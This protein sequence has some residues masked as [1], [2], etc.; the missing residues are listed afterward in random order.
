MN[1]FDMAIKVS[2]VDCA[3]RTQQKM[4]KNKIS[5][6]EGHVTSDFLSFKTMRFF[7]KTNY[8]TVKKFMAYSH[9]KYLCVLLILK[10]VS[11]VVIC[12][13]CKSLKV[14][15]ENPFIQASRDVWPNTCHQIRFCSR[16]LRLTASE[17][18]SPNLRTLSAENPGCNDKAELDRRRL[19]E[20][21]AGRKA[22]LHWTVADPQKRAL[23]TIRKSIEFRMAEMEG[24]ICNRCWVPLSDC[25]CCPAD[26]PLFATMPHRIFIY[27]HH[28]EFG[29]F[30]N[31]G[32]LLL[33]AFPEQTELFIAGLPEHEERIRALLSEVSFSHPK[34]PLP[35]SCN[36][37]HEILNHFSSCSR[38]RPPP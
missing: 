27:L 14:I 38:I 18:S 17:S 21:K 25:V 15:Q 4:Q 20:I 1:W 7:F 33:S 23:A 12:F 8:F 10:T 30:S 31:T 22:E 19:L 34:Q 37:T 24:H 6:S 2:V 5:T 11:P 16:D 36:T 32:A 13:Q 29:R 28:K 26:A 35:P 9:C 3:V